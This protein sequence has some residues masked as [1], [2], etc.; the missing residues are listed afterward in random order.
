MTFT[1]PLFAQNAADAYY[2]PAEM[3]KARAALK[4]SHGQQINTLFLGERFEVHSNDGDSL[5]LLDAQG[6]IGGDVQKLWLKTEAEYETTS[7]RFEGAEIQALYSRAITPFWDLQLG[8]R[9]DI[10]PEPTRSYVVIGAQGMAP[11]WFELDGQLFVSDE[12]DA[13]AR[14]EAE[15]ELRLSQRLILQPRME[16]SVAFSDDEDTSVGAGLSQVEA[17]V[18]LRYEI[19]REFAPYLGVSMNRAFGRTKEFTQAVSEGAEQV[20]FVAGIRFWF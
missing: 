20:S 5:M 18:R 6:W 1:N 9:Q 17:G 19:T 4:S 2:N 15:Y 11:Y 3:D 10:K 14:L 16:L 8:I 12:G 13:S 7:G